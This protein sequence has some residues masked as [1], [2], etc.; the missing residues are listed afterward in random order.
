MVMQNWQRQ[1]LIAMSSKWLKDRCTVEMELSVTGQYGEPSQVW[2][3]VG[4]DVPCRM[5]TAGAGRGNAIEERG[6]QETLKQ[7]YRI[8]LAVT[9]EIGVDCRVT[10]G[11]HVYNVIRVESGLS[12]ELFKQAI[13][14][15]RDG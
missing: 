7:E 10:F 9:T 4:A 3:V 15:R 6:A 2:Q 14:I 8:V 12:D 5:I 1:K 13:V 11:G